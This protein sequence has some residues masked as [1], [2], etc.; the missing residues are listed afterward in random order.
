MFFLV[1]AQPGSP[2]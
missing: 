2:K 1:M